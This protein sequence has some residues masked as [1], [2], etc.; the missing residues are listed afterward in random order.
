MEERRDIGWI[1]GMQ[2]GVGCSPSL[3]E[4][5][6][7]SSLHVLVPAASLSLIVCEVEF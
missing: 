7:L 1:H 5:P 6:L 2:C 3:W 4:A